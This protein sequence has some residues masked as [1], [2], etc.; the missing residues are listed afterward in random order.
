MSNTLLTTAKITNEALFVLFNELTFTRHINRQYD[1]EFGIAGDKIGKTIN[2]RKPPRYLGRRTEALSVENSVESYVPLTLTTPYGVDVSFSNIDL[3]TSV[4]MFSERFIKPA[5]VALANNIDFDGIAQVQN[6]YQAVGTPGTT[7]ST[8]NIYLN[9]AAVLDYASA[10]RTDRFI[11]LNPTA[12]ATI[13]PALQGLFNPTA[14]ISDQYEK[15]LMGKGALGFDWY[16]DQNVVAHTT[17]TYGGTPVV[18]GAGQTGAS[19]VTN[20][21]TATT[22]VLNAGDIFTI[23]GVYSVNPLNRTSTGQLQNFVVTAN[24]VTDG[25]GNS[26]IA[27]SPSI[28]TSGQFQTVTASPANSATITVLGSSAGSFV[29]NVAFHKD[30]FA[31]A[32]CDLMLP[33]GVHE[34]ARASDEQT[35]ISI[36]MVTA[37][38]INTNFMPTRLDVFGGWV[39]LRPELACRV[40]G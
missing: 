5:M 13:I 34:A 7:P 21:W 22:T 26:T 15:G 23:A 2:V 17:G 38:D 3:T 11:C 16:M 10:P 32:C 33:R 35:G 27:I 8:S 14:K 24:T 39:T 1:K 19:L 28:I 31:F 30:A 25:S 37:Y 40:A 29:N 4:D 12:N 6:V 18:N 36:R 9:A 20:G